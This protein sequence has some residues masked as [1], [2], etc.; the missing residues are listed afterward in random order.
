MDGKKWHNKK[1]KKLEKKKLK[2]FLKFNFII[3]VFLF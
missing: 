2:K 3:P 1:L